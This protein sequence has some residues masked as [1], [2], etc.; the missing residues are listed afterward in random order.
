M[1]GEV[2]M[3]FP[4]YNNHFAICIY[5]YI[6]TYIFHVECLQYVPSEVN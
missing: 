3:N 4:S 5:V 6:H 2:Y 1:E